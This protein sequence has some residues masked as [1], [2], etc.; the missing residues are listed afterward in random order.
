LRFSKELNVKLELY[1][2]SNTHD[3]WKRVA[4]DNKLNIETH[5]TAVEELDDFFLLN[6]KKQ[7]SDIIVFCSARPGSVS[8]S[9]AVD[10]F[11]SKLEK[12]FPKN[13]YLLIFPS[14]QQTDPVYGSYE[15]IDSTAISRGVEA[16]QKIGKEVGNIFKKGNQKE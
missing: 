11:P 3:K 4:E 6:S 16:I 7:S 15:D 10:L 1:A 14:Q 8:Y 9:A 2:T 12:A 13:D 5:W